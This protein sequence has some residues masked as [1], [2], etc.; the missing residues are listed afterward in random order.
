MSPRREMLLK[1]VGLNPVIHPANIDED[2]TWSGKAPSRVVEDL[3]RSKVERVSVSFP[4]DC[5][6][7]ADTIV[8][9]DD[10]ILGKPVDEEEAKAMLGKI[11]GRKHVVYTGVALYS[12]KDRVIRTDSDATSV[13]IRNLSDDEISWYVSTGEPMD[14]AGSYALQ[15]IGGLFVT[16]VEGDYS[17]VIGL[18]LPKVYQ[19]FQDAGIKELLLRGILAC[20]GE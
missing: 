6:L 9:I 20:E 11:S 17:S 14:K 5:V 1:A 18:P 19:L 12:P 13:Y 8:S 15:G 3:A 10:E 2:K 7:G 16:R 4:N